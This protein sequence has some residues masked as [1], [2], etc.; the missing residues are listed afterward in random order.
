MLS[1]TTNG[2]GMETGVGV[3]MVTRKGWFLMSMEMNETM[4]FDTRLARLGAVGYMCVRWFTRARTH[5]LPFDSHHT[6]EFFR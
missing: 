1:M 6:E 2:H 5:S 3:E 4:A